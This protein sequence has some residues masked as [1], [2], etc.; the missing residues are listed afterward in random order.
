MHRDL[1]SE[2][3]CCNREYSSN[4]IPLDAVENPVPE[5]GLREAVC[6]AARAI[7][8]SILKRRAEGLAEVARLV[9]T[10][11]RLLD[12]INLL[13]IFSPSLVSVKR[14]HKTQNPEA[15]YNSKIKTIPGPQAGWKPDAGCAVCKGK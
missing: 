6:A 4:D 2:F 1:G 11:T 14:V 15:I 8:T 3:Y 10:R 9:L 13:E 7:R 5:G 12:Y